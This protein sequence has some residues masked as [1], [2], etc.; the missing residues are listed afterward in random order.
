MIRTYCLAAGLLFSITTVA[1]ANNPTLSPKDRT[2]AVQL[3]SKLGHPSFKV[4]EPCA[5]P[6]RG[7][8][9]VIGSINSELPFRHGARKTVRAQI[10][11]IGLH[12]ASVAHR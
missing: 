5:L 8:A 6:G 12:H 7:I 3:V 11:P 4:R 1:L 10:P 2:E 9:C